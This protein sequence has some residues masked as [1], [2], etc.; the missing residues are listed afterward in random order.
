MKFQPTKQYLF[1][2]P[3]KIVLPSPDVAGETVVEEFI[4]RFRLVQ[5]EEAKALQTSILEAKSAD[6][7]VSATK[8]QIRALLVGWDET[9]VLDDD[10]RPTRFGMEVL[11]TYMHSAQF[12]DGVLNSYSEA[13]AKRPAEGN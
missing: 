2:W 5:D 13:L 6:E 8:A 9:T 12:R 7:F 4:G 11:E 1:P 10:N 3:I